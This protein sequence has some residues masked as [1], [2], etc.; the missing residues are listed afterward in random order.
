MAWAGSDQGRSF[1]YV[2]GDDQKAVYRPVTLGPLLDGLRIVREGLNA[3]ERIVV[4]GL[5]SARPGLPVTP[6]L[7]DMRVNGIAAQ[8]AAK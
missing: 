3:K 2:I 8:A 5:M 7:V 4:S 6:Q 1:V